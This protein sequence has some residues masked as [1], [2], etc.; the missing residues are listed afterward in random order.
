MHLRAMVN[1]SFKKN[2]EKRKKKIN[3]LIAFF[4]SYKSSVKTFP[5][6]N[7]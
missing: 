1:N 5:K 4:I 6:I 2:Y 3:V 7:Y